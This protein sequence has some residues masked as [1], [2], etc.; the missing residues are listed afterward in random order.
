MGE[1]KARKIFPETHEYSG[2]KIWE[3]ERQE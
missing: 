2:Q 1:K 3:K